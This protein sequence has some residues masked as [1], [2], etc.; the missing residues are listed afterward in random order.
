MCGLH[1]KGRAF[2]GVASQVLTKTLCS[3]AGVEADSGI[4]DA[5][6]DCKKVRSG[7]RDRVT[8]PCDARCSPVTLPRTWSSPCIR[9]GLGLGYGKNTVCIAL[10]SRP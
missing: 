8:V 6:L 2:G 5:V 3:F 4:E 9:A 10:P 7:P 1:G